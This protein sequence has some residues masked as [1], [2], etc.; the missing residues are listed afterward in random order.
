MRPSHS[1]ISFQ[2]FLSR[3]ELK[4]LSEY[5]LSSPPSD[6]FPMLHSEALNRLLT[7]SVRTGNTKFSVFAQPL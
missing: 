2:A 3:N 1:K 7:T 6:T 4:H 5:T